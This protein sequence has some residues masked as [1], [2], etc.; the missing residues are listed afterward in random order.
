MTTK[1][2]QAYNKE[3]RLKN[4]ETLREYHKKYRREHPQYLDKHNQRTRKD[5][6]KLK[7]LIFSHYFNG[8]IK[9]QKCGIKDIRLLQLHHYEGGGAKQRREQLG[10]PNARG[11]TFYYWLKK[12]NFPKIKLEPVC[13][14]CHILIR[15]DTPTIKKYENNEN[16][17]RGK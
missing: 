3:Y 10:N 8:N 1:Q 15:Y 14:N 5:W 13:A 6:Q 16:R 9:C 2:K 12:N 7:Q 4:I 11:S 17:K